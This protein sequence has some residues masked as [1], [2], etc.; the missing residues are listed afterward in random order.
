V[1]GP[2]ERLQL[3]VT[4]QLDIISV[5]D[6]RLVKISGDIDIRMPCPADSVFLGS[7]AVVVEIMVR[8]CRS[9]PVFASMD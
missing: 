4:G 1:Y 3:N 2:D 6:D 7:V 5:S 8:R 9:K